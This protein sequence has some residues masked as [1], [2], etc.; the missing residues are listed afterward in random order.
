MRLGRPLSPKLCYAHCV[1]HFDLNFK[2]LTALLK[3][4]ILLRERVP[5]PLTVTGYLVFRVQHRPD[6]LFGAT[7]FL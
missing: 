5:Q 7:L 4:I 6:Q 2:L 3:D 1:G